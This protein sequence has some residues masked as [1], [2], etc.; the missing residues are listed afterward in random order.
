[1]AS[2]RSGARSLDESERLS[3]LW[4]H[5]GA[6]CPQAIVWEQLS[7]ACGREQGPIAQQCN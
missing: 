3:D 6:F 7:Q 4:S 5:D 1:M 2:V